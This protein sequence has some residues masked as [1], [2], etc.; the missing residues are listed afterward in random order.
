MKI[1]PARATAGVVFRF[2]S[3]CKFKKLIEPLY[4]GQSTVRAT[5]LQAFYIQN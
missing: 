1:G 4:G 5:V 3:L 2:F